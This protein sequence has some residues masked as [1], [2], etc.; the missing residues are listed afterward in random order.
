MK[1]CSKLLLLLAFFHNTDRTDIT[2]ST[3]TIP[4]KFAMANKKKKRERKTS[5]KK[6]HLRSIPEFVTEIPSSR[7]VFRWNNHSLRF[8][9][10]RKFRLS[11]LQNE[12]DQFIPSSALFGDFS[13]HNKNPIETI[14]RSGICIQACDSEFAILSQSSRDEKHHRFSENSRLVRFGLGLRNFLESILD[15]STKFDLSPLFLFLENDRFPTEEVS[16]DF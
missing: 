15:R 14:F 10:F 8:H 12:S 6:N 2:N 9:L 1:F 4:N 7:I 13:C 11:K 5:E 16:I 3:K